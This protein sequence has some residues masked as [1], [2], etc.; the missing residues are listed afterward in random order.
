VSEEKLEQRAYRKYFEDQAQTS[1]EIVK[2]MADFAR[3][4]R[5]AVIEK[6][7]RIVEDTPL[8]YRTEDEHAKLEAFADKVS[9][10]IRRLAE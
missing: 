6:A 4:E 3:L 10:A 9:V 5:N 7:A 8:G 2:S 1:G